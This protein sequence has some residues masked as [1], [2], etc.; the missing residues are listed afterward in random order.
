MITLITMLIVITLMIAINAL[1]VAGEF[2][3]VSAR[4]ARITQLAE[5]GHR[6]A[7]LLLPILENPRA[8]DR[9][10]AASQVGITLSSIVLGIYGQQQIAPRIAP[11][12]ERLPIIDSE[13]AAAG[14]AATLVLIT[15]T[16]LQVILG[17]LVP[18]SLAIQYP[19]RVALATVLPMRW[20]SDVILRPF[21]SL[22]NGSGV[23]ILRL[24]G[25]Q[26]SGH[27][28]VHS[29]EEIQ[30]LIQQS[31]AGGLLD[32]EER[33][34]LDKAF[35]VGDL[36]A[37]DIV[38][39]RTK[40][41][42]ASRQMPLA[43]LLHLAAQEDYTRIPIYEGDVDHIVGI[44]HLKDLFRLYRQGATDISPI[45]RKV[46]FV[47][48]TMSMND[49]W[50]TLNTQQTYVAIVVDEFGGTAGMVTREDIIEEVLGDVRD[51]FDDDEPKAITRV[52]ERQYLVLGDTAIAHVNDALKVS[53]PSDNA[54][55]LG[56][57]ILDRLGRI[58]QI[59]DT[60]DVDG[61]ILQAHAVQH[62]TATRILLTL[63][64]A[65]HDEENGEGIP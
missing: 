30:L 28:H 20:S 33:D 31:H 14:V 13:L 46:A 39:P 56:G 24:L 42:A 50:Q 51:E 7:R 41:I 38:V 11:L 16:A 22:L 58:P 49:L 23:L 19:E 53:L 61:V 54:H 21:I 48:E 63:P 57:L 36:T 47:P 26:H 1:Y 10:I 40:M 29:P 9:Y 4:R 55:S 17:E 3:A 65:I 62:H 64:H 35:R 27:G 12:V 8:L 60:V 18:K 45:L 34:M 5:E 25:V 44:V 52:G 6:F 15:L 43:D 2:A 32:E 37:A 59:G